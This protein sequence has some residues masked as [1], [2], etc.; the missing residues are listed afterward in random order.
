MSEFYNK[1]I[2][3]KVETNEQQRSFLKLKRTKKKII[4]KV[5]TDEQHRDH[6]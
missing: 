5:E 2:T 4:F 6:F 1:E 3:F